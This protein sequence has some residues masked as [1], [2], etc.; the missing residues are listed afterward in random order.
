[1]LNE[2]TL[3]DVMINENQY[4]EGQN[5]QKEKSNGKKKNDTKWKL[6]SVISHKMLKE[7]SLHGRDWQPVQENQD[8][9]TGRDQ[10]GLDCWD[11]TART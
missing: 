7:Q 11:R 9:T 10:L 6:S 3:N 8:R 4:L 5:K 1:M 2:K